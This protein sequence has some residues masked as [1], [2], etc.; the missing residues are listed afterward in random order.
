MWVAFYWHAARRTRQL[1]CTQSNL[2][3]SN[4]LKRLESQILFMAL[5]AIVAVIGDDCATLVPG[6]SGG[7][8]GIDL[9]GFFLFICLSLCLPTG[10]A[11][12]ER[13]R[14]FRAA[15]SSVKIRISPRYWSKEEKFA[16]QHFSALAFVALTYSA[17][18][19]GPHRTPSQSNIFGPPIR[20]QDPRGAERRDFI[21]RAAR[22]P[23]LRPGR[24]IASRRSIEAHTDQSIIVRTKQR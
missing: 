23:R 13:R 1:I 5:L 16:S 17:R 15:V 21:S 3:G 6:Q 24:M 22:P 11:P 2:V 8:Q 10:S 14:D 4:P 7:H 9:G 20:R 19:I 18:C 12:A